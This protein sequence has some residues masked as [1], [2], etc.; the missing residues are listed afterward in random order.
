MKQGNGNMRGML[1]L[2]AAT[3]AMIS[4]PVKGNDYS[5]TMN[6]KTLRTK[7][8]RRCGAGRGQGLSVRQY[9]RLATKRRNRTAYR[10]KVKNSRK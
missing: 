7:A 1:A 3:M 2:L 10:T 5:G 4:S 9:S 6:P 8:E